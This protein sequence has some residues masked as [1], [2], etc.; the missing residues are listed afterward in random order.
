VGL[1]S[2]RLNSVSG[3]EDESAR[4]TW[5]TRRAARKTK[6]MRAAILCVVA[7][8]RPRTELEL[9]SKRL[10][11]RL[12]LRTHDSSTEILGALCGRLGRKTANKH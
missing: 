11:Y 8:T 5:K 1:P 12:V 3:T 4:L 7:E 10:F 2:Q 9:L 6:A